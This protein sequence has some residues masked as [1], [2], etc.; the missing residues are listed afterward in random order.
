VGFA[1]QESLLFSAT[2]RENIAFGRP[3]ATEEEILAAA[4]AADAHNFI[5]EFPEGYDTLVGERGITLSGGQKQ[6][7]AIARAILVDP[8]ILVLDDSTSAVDTQ[9]EYSIQQALKGIMAGRTTFIIAQRLTSVM[10]AE[11]ILVMDHGRIAERGTH[12]ELLAQGGLY[13]DIYDLQ[14]ADQERVRRETVDFAKIQDFVPA[15]GD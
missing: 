9:T 11:Q 2:I 1:L 14:L 3:D 5:M 10:H 13:K 4:K 15:A 12:D 8:A 6:R 7:T